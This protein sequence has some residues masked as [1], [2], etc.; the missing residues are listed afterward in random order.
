[1]SVRTIFLMIRGSYQAGMATRMAREDLRKLV[2]EQREVVKRTEDMMRAAN[3]WIF[4]GAAFVTFGSMMTKSFMKIMESSTAGR[5]ALFDFSRRTRA[6]MQRLSEAFSPIMAQV[7]DVVSGFMELVT[8]N[9]VLRA[10]AVGVMLV[11]G[12]LLLLAG[13]AILTTGGVNALAVAYKLL[14]NRSIE[15]TVATKAF[16]PALTQFSTGTYV[17]ASNTRTLT[18]SMT[19]LAVAVG[20]AL[21]GFTMAYSIVSLLQT[22][23]G[24][25]NS[26]IIA[27]TAVIIGMAIALWSGAG[28]MSVLTFGLAAIAGIGAATAAASQFPVPSYQTGTSFVKQGGMAMLH[29]GE[30]IIS[31]R[32]SRATSLVEKGREQRSTSNQMSKSTTTV[33][34]A[35][36]TV[37]T[38]SN[39]DDVQEKIGI[40]IKEALDNKV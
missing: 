14:K 6:S 5:K 26:A 12:P 11:A 29:G 18:T 7:L 13:I 27:L 31:A 22:K 25:I 35:I 16:T 40:A 4:A 17:A 1:M 19:G 32:E 34:V 36:S 20:R 30:E 15:A 33:N 37:N 8:I 23:F 28:A 10:V 21:A 24:T 39:F 3:Q 2:K 38:K 9:P